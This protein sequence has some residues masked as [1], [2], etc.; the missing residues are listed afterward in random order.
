VLLRARIQGR[1]LLVPVRLAFEGT[2]SAPAPGRS[3]VRSG[4]AAD[5]SIASQ[6]RA[7]T[8]NAPLEFQSGDAVIRH[9]A[10]IEREAERE[11]SAEGDEAE[12]APAEAEAESGA[13]AAPRE[14][15]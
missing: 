13:P 6:I 1:G 5:C 11:A 3:R 15:P 9:A 12:P 4:G 7:M 8:G 2:R 10:Q 14:G